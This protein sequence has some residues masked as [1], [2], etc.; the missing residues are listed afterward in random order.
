MEISESNV[1]TY[2]RDT[3]RAAAEGEILVQA[4]S[5][6]ESGNVVLKVFDTTAGAK[7]GSDLRTP[8]QLKQGRPDERMTQGDCYVLK[9]PR[10]RDGALDLARIAQEKACM[11]LLTA[12]LP[13]GSVPE[14]RWFDDANGVLAMSCSPPESVLWLKQ[15]STGAVSM[16]AASLAGVLLAMVHSSTK[17]DAAVKEKFGDG[18]VLLKQRIEPMFRATTAKHA[19]LAKTL[20]DALFRLRS[21]MAL[22]HGDFR[23]ENVL[24]I[25]A[26]EGAVAEVTGKPKT[27][28]GPKVGHL[29][30]VD[31][32]SA[33]FGHNAFDVATMV[34]DLLLMGFISLGRWRAFMML[35]DNFWQT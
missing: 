2:L 20:Q 10:T 13:A 33:Y 1:I 29:T 18:Q 30:L 21:P 7:I 14:V 31:F 5:T 9:Q 32:E 35:A 27:A 17:K 12:H 23:P 28:G 8:G 15:L 24:L 6:P 26:P 25:P 3:G 4:L 34:S 19:G 16:D 11:E 22:I